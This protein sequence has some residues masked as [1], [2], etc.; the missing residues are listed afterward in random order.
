VTVTPRLSSSVIL[1]RDLAGGGVAV[2]MLRRPLASSFAAGSTATT[3][4]CS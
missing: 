1:L 3:A 4:P 2:Y